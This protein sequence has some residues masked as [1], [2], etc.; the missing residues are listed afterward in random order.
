MWVALGSGPRVSCAV[1]SASAARSAL[2]AYAARGLRTADENEGPDIVEGV[3]GP[4]EDREEVTDVVSASPTLA[5][6]LH[7]KPYYPYAIAK[8]LRPT[9]SRFYPESAPKIFKKGPFLLRR[10]RGRYGA[11]T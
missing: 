10:R 11:T 4:V 9:C 7:S 1:F 6:T 8:L 5:I 3:A 2:E